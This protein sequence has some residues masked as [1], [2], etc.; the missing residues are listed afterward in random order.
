[1]PLESTSACGMGGEGVGMGDSTTRQRERLSCKGE[2]TTIFDSQWTS[3][4]KMDVSELPFT[5]PR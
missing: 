4:A 1:M 2:L 3:E 5:D